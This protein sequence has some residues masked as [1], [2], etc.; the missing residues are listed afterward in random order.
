M[1]RT[2]ALALAWVFAFA[3]I[4]QPA[5]AADKTPIGIYSGKQKEFPA[6]DTVGVPK[7]GT[8]RTTL[9]NHGVLVGQATSAVAATAAGTTGQPLLSGGASADPAYGTLAVGAGGTGSTTAST[10]RTALGV[11][12]GSDVEAWDA[13]LDSL[14]AASTTGNM[15]YRS[16]TSTWAPVTVGS[17]CTFTTGTLACAGTGGGGG[18]GP[19][20]IS[21]QTFSGA[22]TVTFSS[23]PGTYTHLMLEVIVRSSHADTDVALRLQFNGDTAS[24]Y[25]WQY[26]YGNGSTA[27][28]QAYAAGSSDTYIKLADVSAA[29]APSGDYS[30]LRSSID[31]YTV[32]ARKIVR[33]ANNLSRA[34][35]TTGNFVQDY[36]GVWKSTTTPTSITVTL[37]N[38]TGATGSTARL[39]GIP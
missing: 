8:G 26:F 17:G 27:S 38:G 7:G 3:S 18:S 32:S 21:T 22:S 37:A 4:I 20:V 29:N 13:D 28:A 1:R 10:A 33:T 2:A 24:N 35:S 16:A 39:I 30:I 15:Y 5:L 23:I 12:I 6:G 14:A 34:D 11:A 9:T 36:M 19:T 25:M 31:W